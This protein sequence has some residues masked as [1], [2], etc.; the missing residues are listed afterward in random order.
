MI[1]NLLREPLVHFAII[2]LGLF[3]LFSFVNTEESDTE[4]I[5]DEYDLNE[6]VS[7]W[8]LQWQR[9]PT[10]Q[11]LK[12]L[13]DGY[14]KQEILYREA[15][16][17]N[18]DHNDEIIRRRMAQKMQFLTQDVV[19][20]VPPGEEELQSFLEENQSKYKSDMLISFEHIYFS[21][22]LRSDA[23]LDAEN[24]LKSNDPK[25]DQS[26]IRSSFEQASLTRISGDF[27]Q[28]FVDALQTKTASDSWQGPI[29]SGLGYH[30]VKVTEIID[31]RNLT[32]DEVRKKV[33]TDYQY[34]LRNQL[35]ET[36]YETLLKKYEV[37]IELDD[38][39]L[40]MIED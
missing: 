4:I 23:R 15:L 14:I 10:P 3:V 12:G 40:K 29:A 22:D 1:K 21:H 8:N 32:L 36:L 6:I 37:S 18:L 25:G 5:I 9:D 26:P 24:A 28:K 33:V 38:E 30:L 31:S 35:N 34:D 17:M 39:R 16:S 13:L 20:R 27:G 7:K 2:G 19:E 11:E